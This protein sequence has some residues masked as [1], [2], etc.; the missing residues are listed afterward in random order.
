MLGRSV[1]GEEYSF[2]EAFLALADWDPV[3]SVAESNS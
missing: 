1:D 3:V 2:S